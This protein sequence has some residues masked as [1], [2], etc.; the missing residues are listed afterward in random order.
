ML[1]FEYNYA[2]FVDNL[3]EEKLVSISIFTEEEA[4]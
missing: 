1:I 3:L 4:G 2:A